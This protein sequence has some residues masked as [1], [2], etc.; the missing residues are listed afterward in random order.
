MLKQLYQVTT[1]VAIILAESRDVE[2]TDDPV[3]L[4]Y[5]AVN[6]EKGK[7]PGLVRLRMIYENEK[8]DWWDLLMVGPEDMNSIATKAGWYLEKV[9]KDDPDGDQYHSN[10]YVGVLRKR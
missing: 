8:S 3:H 6:R 4:D 10:V 5:H 2:D 9:I 1:E 7:L